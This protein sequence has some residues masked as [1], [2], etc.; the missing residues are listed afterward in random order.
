[1]TRRVILGTAAVRLPAAGEILLKGPRTH[2]ADRPEFLPGPVAGLDEL[3]DV[4]HVACP[5]P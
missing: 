3:F 4:C 2:V 1:M 5:A